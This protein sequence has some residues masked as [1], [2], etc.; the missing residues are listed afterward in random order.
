MLEFV[1]RLDL[2][3]ILMEKEFS[4]NK[5]YG[6]QKKKKIFILHYLSSTQRHVFMIISLTCMNL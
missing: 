4:M 1:L 6:L 2:E 3:R 5:M